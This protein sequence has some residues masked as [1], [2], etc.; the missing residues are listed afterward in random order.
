M[1]DGLQFVVGVRTLEAR[2]VL[3][4]SLGTIAACAPDQATAGSATFAAE[5]CATGATLRGIDV[6]AWQGV[7]DWQAVAGD[8]I[9]FA[10]VRASHGLDGGDPYFAENWAGTKANGI[11]RGAYQYFTPEADTLAQADLLLATMGPLLPGDLPPVLDIEDHGGLSASAL[12]AE[13]ARWLDHVEAAIGRKPLIY[14]GKYFWQD[15][16]GSDAFAE[17]PLWVAQWGVTCPDLPSPW[18]R[19]TFQQTSAT[20]SIA[21]VGGDVDTDLFNGTLAELGALAATE[22]DGCTDC[23]TPRCEPIP[24]EGRILEDEDLC[25]SLG[26]SASSIRNVDGQGWESDLAW[27]YTTDWQEADNFGLWTL[28]LAASGRYRV[29]AY[30]AAPWAESRR[31]T[32][33]IRHAGTVDRVT[34]DQ[35][36]VDGW[37][38]LGDFDF[39]AGGDQWVRLPDNTGEPLSGQTQLVFDAL[40]LGPP[41]DDPAAD[42]PGQAVDEAGCG[43][44]LGRRPRPG[45]LA[46]LAVVAAAAA[47]LTFGRGRRREGL[48]D[49]L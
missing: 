39:A 28:E 3:V 32:Y 48:R 40:R 20:G 33:E 22:P 15:H 24:P 49:A 17:H 1:A 42:D 7:I 13:A 30:T 14:T 5:V 26:G 6:S 47:A 46:L 18:A 36:A 38:R 29:E 10:F 12:A 41:S 19:W 8:G 25:F 35:A 16:V 2:L 21:G 34:V 37:T 27:T 45:T 9:Q 23:P 44:Q 11:V 31:A 4:G 43:C